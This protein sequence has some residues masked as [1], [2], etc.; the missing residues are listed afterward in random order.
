MAAFRRFRPQKTQLSALAVA[1]SAAVYSSWNKKRHI[2]RNKID[3]K[4]H[5]H[6]HTEEKST[7]KQVKG[8]SMA[9]PPPDLPRPRRFPGPA[10]APEQGSGGDRQGLVEER[11]GRKKDT[12]KEE[13]ARRKRC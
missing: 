7:K 12:R 5:T 6:T 13:K 1:A 2:Q 4:T 9:A 10:G 3:I 8:S 11:K